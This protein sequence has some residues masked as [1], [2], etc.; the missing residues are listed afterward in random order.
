M[1]RI[2]SAL[3]ALTIILTLVVP[4]SAV[5]K[6]RAPRLTSLKNTNKGVVVKWKTV[7]NATKYIVFRRTSST[8]YIKRATVKTISFTD[9]K[10][11]SGRKYIYAVRSVNAKGQ[12]KLSKTKTITSIGTPKLKTW[13]SK[14]ALKAKWTKVRKATK[15][16]LLYKKAKAKKYK[17]LYSGTKRSFANDN[18]D[19]GAAYNLKVKAV[20]GKQ[21]G[22]YSPAK[23]QVFLES[24]T[25]KAEELLDMEGITLKWS[26]IN[27]AKGYIIYR[28]LK[29][30]NSYK[31]I[32]KVSADIKRYVDTDVVSINS[33]KYYVVAYN[34]SS[35][36]AKSNIDSDVYGYIEN[37][38]TP[39]TLTIKKGEVY[40][41]IYIKLNDYAAVSFIKW[42]SSNS[43]IAKVNSK[44]IITGVKKGKATL[45][46]VIDKE[47]IAAY[48]PGATSSKTIKIIVTVK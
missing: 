48:K 27:S 12:S 31:R 1:K 6:P 34:G 17:V 16:V 15:Y 22:A 33:Y 9:K 20:I 2:I 26:A 41:D 25:L 3:A 35:K 21:N 5:T 19:S 44:G 8:K 10:A 11:V 30:A 29:S 40:K 47:F 32:K 46:A 28:S 36:S 24:P 45:K 4:A 43:K 39:L 18:I 38:S 42:S 13:N 23:T 14:Y 37:T 7:K